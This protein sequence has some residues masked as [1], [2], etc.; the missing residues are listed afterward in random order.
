MA[1]GTLG[2]GIEVGLRQP[3]QAQMQ[4][5]RGMS[6]QQD[7]GDYGKY[8]DDILQGEYEDVDNRTMG[9]FNSW[10]EARSYAQAMHKN[11]GIDV[12]TP[13]FSNPASIMANRAFMQKMANLRDEANKAKRG[14]EARNIQLQNQAA[15]PNFRYDTRGEGEFTTGDSFR[16]VGYTDEQEYL[17]QESL[18]PEGDPASY[19]KARQ[20]KQAILANH[21]AEIEKA[22]Q[23]G[24]IRAIDEA[25]ESKARTEAMQIKLEQP[26][27]SQEALNAKIK[28][29]IRANKLANIMQ[30][31]LD[32]KK[33]P[34]ATNS[35]NDN[36]LGT[37][38]KDGA[39]MY[40]K[41][42]IFPHAG[43]LYAIKGDEMGAE[44]GIR[45]KN[46]HLILNEIVNDGDYEKVTES[47]LAGLGD[48]RFKVLPIADGNNPTE[49]EGRKSV[50]PDISPKF[51]TGRDVMVKMLQD[52][53][54]AGELFNEQSMSNWYLPMT[55]PVTKK[56]KDPRVSSTYKIKNYEVN[57]GWAEIE[58]YDAENP[59]YTGFYKFEVGD[60][61]G[62]EKLGELIGYNYDMG[63]VDMNKEQ[64]GN[65]R[66]GDRP[67]QNIKNNY[68]PD[69]VEVRPGYNPS[70]SKKSVPELI[71]ERAG[72]NL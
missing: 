44:W 36:I 29:S 11:F 19:A 26:A 30:G 8:L 21:D 68:E 17:R 64:Y 14:R 50:I 1:N 7:E 71:R 2:R 51:Y 40:S 20:E 34:L 46:T 28:T 4:A 32:L 15:N 5:S 56:G 62:A 6:P 69:Q 12:M 10:G 13:D 23:A 45:G 31:T 63:V 53:D 41:S 57:N 66:I 39:P 58:V 27:I 65:Y 16:N 9:I 55:W 35:P 22:R 18:Q 61:S 42:N 43:K 54:T 48:P 25:I 49:G 67:I 47:D 60:D 33:N 72:G 24:D 3:Q 59:H 70:G 52:D 37:I 38:S